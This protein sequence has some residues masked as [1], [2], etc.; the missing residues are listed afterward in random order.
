MN[1]MTNKSLH[2]MIYINYTKLSCHIA[3]TVC[4]LF[5]FLSVTQLSKLFLLTQLRLEPVLLVL[6]QHL[7]LGLYNNNNLLIIYKK[8]PKY[9][10][11]SH[12]KV[13]KGTSTITLINVA[14]IFVFLCN[15]KDLTWLILHLKYISV[16]E[17]AS[18]VIFMYSFTLITDH[19]YQSQSLFIN[20]KLKSNADTQKP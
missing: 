20:Q 5:M 18:A 3:Y 14:A 16:T 19:S 8:S 12:N 1:K 2:N 13:Q 4:L 6:I 11:I 17:T 10:A 15:F 9:K 7:Y